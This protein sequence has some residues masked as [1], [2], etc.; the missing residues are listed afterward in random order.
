MDLVAAKLIYDFVEFVARIGSWLRRQSE[1]RLEELD[2]EILNYLA[3]RREWTT[4]G[5][6]WADLVLLPV[7]RDVR[8]EDAF[9]P[10][11]K[12]WPFFKW[13][14]RNLWVN[15]RHR[16]RRWR[17]FIPKEVVIK[18]TRRLWREDRLRRAWWDEL[19]M[20]R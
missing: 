9:P 19:Y 18:R 12:G 6:I 10:A 16:W 5:L 14:L 20:L 1:E 11:L 17:H 8:F 2:T 4:P 13:K 7:L 3:N 15:V